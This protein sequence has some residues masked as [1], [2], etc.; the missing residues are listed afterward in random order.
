MHEVG[1]MQ[2][3][4]DIA[5]KQARASGA[6]AIHEIRLRIGQMTGVV[7]EA[8]EHAFV[9]LREGTMSVGAKLAVEYV[10]AVFWC[11]NCQKEFEQPGLFCECPECAIPSADVR[12]GMEMEIVSLEVD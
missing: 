10:R 1:I 11:A 2:S 7:P 6:T 12:S 4:L 8:L 9:V 3:A 5:E